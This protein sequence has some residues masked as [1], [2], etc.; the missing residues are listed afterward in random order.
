MRD[1]RDAPR[2]HS[3]SA[4]SLLQILHD[5]ND[6]ALRQVFGRD[7]M[8]I[9][10]AMYSF[11]VLG[12]FQSSVSAMLQPL[13]QEYTI[14]Y[15][16]VS[17]VFVAGPSG[18]IIAAQCSDYVHCRWGR[19]GV[20][21]LAPSLACLGALLTA[22]RPPFS[23]V[24]MAYTFIALGLGLLDVSWCAW[25]ASLSNAHIASGLLQAAFSVG[26][27]TGPF[28]ASSALSSWNRPWSDWYYIMVSL[29][30]EQYSRMK[31]TRDRSGGCIRSR[32]MRLTSRVPGRKC[33]EI[34]Q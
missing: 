12:L 23:L 24:L 20:A 7:S 4:E 10:A 19:R 21:I 18:Y 31:L 3:A 15:L 14:E 29:K 30:K 2:T 26:A 1:D 27:A 5:D 34:S 25:A 6:H 13:M 11:L 22:L 8:R 32:A 9:F 16:Y 28:L 17:T 33:I